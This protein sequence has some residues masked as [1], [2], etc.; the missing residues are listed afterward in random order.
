V[1]QQPVIHT[2]RLR[3]RPLTPADAARV[4]EL[5]SEREVAALTTNIPHPYAD[6]MAERWVSNHLGQYERGE[7]AT[8]AVVPA[9]EDTLIGAVSL[10]F[11]S[12]HNRAEISYWL[13]APY[14]G[15]GYAPE[16]VGAAVRYAFDRRSLQKVTSSV[17]ADNQRSVRVLEKLGFSE[18]GR[19]RR[20]IMKWEELHDLLRF[21]LLKEEYTSQLEGGAPIYSLIKIE[22]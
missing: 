4:Q 10:H 1:E 12:P 13:G 9:D 16:A 7:L 3:L 17:L 11:D 19:Q 20:Q 2:V 6:G 5:A 8:W 18:E 14:W 15:Q 22:S 21:G